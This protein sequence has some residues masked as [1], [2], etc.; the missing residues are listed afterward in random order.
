MARMALHS[1]ASRQSPMDQRLAFKKDEKECKFLS[2]G[3]ERKNYFFRKQKDAS[4][5]TFRGTVDCGPG[6]GK[7]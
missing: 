1:T 5:T 3:P 6:S 7:K 2:G 4:D